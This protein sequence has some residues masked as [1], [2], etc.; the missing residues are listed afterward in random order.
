MCVA[1]LSLPT[2]VPASL[3]ALDRGGIRSSATLA[4]I[5][6][7]GGFSLLA[8]FN[9]YVA[10]ISHEVL[11]AWIPTFASTTLCA[12]VS[13]VTLLAAIAIG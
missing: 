6:D 4:D 5:F 10:G 3:Y 9:G 2:T 12:S 7:I 13:F 8:V 11:R 1:Y